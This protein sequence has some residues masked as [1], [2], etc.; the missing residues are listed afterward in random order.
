QTR[1]TDV[2]G[3]IVDNAIRMAITPPITG[4]DKCLL[5]NPPFKSGYFLRIANKLKALIPQANA[6]K[7][8][9][10]SKKYVSAPFPSQPRDNTNTKVM[11][12]ARLGVPYFGCTLAK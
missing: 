1:E 6:V 3:I 12:I 8:P 10:I 9:P 11:T 2:P 4:S 7:K 5:R